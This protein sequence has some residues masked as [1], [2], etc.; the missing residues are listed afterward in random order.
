MPERPERTPDVTKEVEKRRSFEV[1][2]INIP[3]LK[4][5]EDIRNQI[6]AIQT[7]GAGVDTV[8][9][10]EFSLEAR[11]AIQHLDELRELAKENDT[12][13]ILA[14][15]NRYRDDEEGKSDQ[16]VQIKSLLKAAGTTVEDTEYPGSNRP[17]SIGIFVGKDGA[18]FAFPKNPDN[19]VHRVPGT[20]IGV[21]I[22]GEIGHINPEDLQNIEV[23][24]NPS[25]EHDDQLVRFRMAQEAKGLPLTR[26]E[27]ER[28]VLEENSLKE[29]LYDEAAYEEYRRKKNEELRKEIGDEQY[30]R[31][32]NDEPLV[33]P[34]E[35]VE[36]RR[37]QFDKHID[38]LFQKLAGD[39]DSFYVKTA[40][41]LAEA[42]REKR[43]PII[44]ADGMGNS[45]VLNKI[46]GMKFKD[47]NVNRR[48]TRMSLNI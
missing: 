20:K 41:G 29:L 38:S 15:E 16:W 21:T 2:T 17:D 36:E 37:R 48:R 39:Y 6:D 7:E 25:E 43:I 32:F 5:V 27:I 45:G 44:R 42:L 46:E 8:V 1:A 13:L 26:D 4:T 28:L 30:D 23:L 18:V 34:D 24:F 22:C 12:D 40:P 35:T 10:M 33:G 3:R 11:Y 19:P 47:L 14:P 9:V 31:L